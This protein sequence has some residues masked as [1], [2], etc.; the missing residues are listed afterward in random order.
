MYKRFYSF[1]LVFV[2]LLFSGCSDEKR[3]D[4]AAL[5]ET[6]SVSIENGKVSYNF[7]M[8]NGEEDVKLTT[9]NAESF[10]QA[11]FLA[12]E[13]YKPNLSLAKLELVIFDEKISDKVFKDDIE[14]LSKNDTLSPLVM[15]TLA[16]L[17]TLKSM[18]DNKD[19]PKQVEELIMLVKKKTSET[20]INTLSIFN[21]FKSKAFSYF[22]I[23][24]INSDK[25]L[26]VDFRLISSN[27][28]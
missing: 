9:I 18:S 11:Y 5:A 1:G 4:R 25:E 24:Y 22:Y 6:V 28:W 23:P 27:K 8:L 20:K 26:N 21:S 15:V 2:M 13:K 10:S 14:Y 17:K 3:I 19:I 7:F 12:K 16:D